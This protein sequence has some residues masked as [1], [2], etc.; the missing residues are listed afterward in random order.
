MKK[1]ELLKTLESYPIFAFND[2][3]RITRKSSEY[4]RVMLFRLKKEKLIYQIERGKYSLHDD[5]MIFSSYIIVPSYISFWTALRFY[6]LTEQ[7]PRDIMIASPKSKKTINFQGTR[8]SFFK[9]RHLW[10]YKRVRYLDFDIFVAEKE[11]CIID[12]LLMKN[13]PFDE[14]IK[15]LRSREINTKKLTEYAIRTK[16]IALVKRL[17][18]IMENLGL[19]FEDLLK[20]TDNNYIPLDMFGE[21]KGTKDRKWKIIV[22]RRLDDIY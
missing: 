1:I 2:F 22:N 13:V 17:G 21:K 5:P 11:K 6:N 15:A 4:A 19:D 20:H 8:I 9:S 12:C 18:F 7:L 16:N 10:G 14:I 3:V